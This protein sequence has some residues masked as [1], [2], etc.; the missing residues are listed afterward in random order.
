VT[1]RPR[2]VLAAGRVRSS[3]RPSP[4][5]VAAYTRKKAAGGSVPGLNEV[6]IHTA[7]GQDMVLTA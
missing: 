3:R 7:N 1:N 5:N 4:R 6:S 2:P